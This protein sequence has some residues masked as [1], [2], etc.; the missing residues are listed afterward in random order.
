MNAFS[1]KR[2]KD[3]FYVSFNLLGKYD[4]MVM[5]CTSFAKAC[6]CGRLRACNCFRW[7]VEEERPFQRSGLLRGNTKNLISLNSFL[8][9]K[10]KIF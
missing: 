7:S 1:Y 6:D 2:G 5:S 3:S 9:I 10:N 4:F 8:H